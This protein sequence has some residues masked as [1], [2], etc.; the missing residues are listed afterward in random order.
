MTGSHTVL[1]CEDAVE[2]EGEDVDGGREGIPAPVELLRS[3]QYFLQ[4]SV[5]IG[6]RT[7]EV[8]SR[9]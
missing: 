6:R 1:G 7:S 3:L 9:T 2:S 4:G 5:T 8:R